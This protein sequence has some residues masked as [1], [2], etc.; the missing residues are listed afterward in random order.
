MPIDLRLKGLYRQWWELRLEGAAKLDKG[1][2]FR[3]KDRRSYTLSIFECSSY[4]LH[5]QTQKDY[6]VTGFV[7]TFA[8]L[9]KKQRKGE[10]GLSI[11][12][13]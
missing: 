4:F 7:T 6:A 9:I 1:E 5:A 3:L 12:G 11:F 10:V 13:Y 2:M 8:Y